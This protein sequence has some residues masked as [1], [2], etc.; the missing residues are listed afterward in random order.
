[1]NEKFRKYM[2]Y[3]VGEIALIVVGIFIAL[4]IDNWNS[5]RQEEAALD[6][7]LQSIMGNVRNDLVEIQR[8]QELRGRVLLQSQQA[9]YLSTMPH[10]PIEAVFF[11][12]RGNELIRNKAHFIPNTSG[13]EALKSSGVLSKLHGRD[14]EKLLFR[15]YD[16][17]DR[18]QLLERD[19][20]AAQ[21]NLASR[22]EMQLPE[23]FQNYTFFDPSGLT[24]G[25]FEE[26]QPV[27]RSFFKSYARS[28]DLNTLRASILPIVREYD[29]LL[30]LGKN[31]VA[32]IE[33]DADTFT[34]EA[35]NTLRKLDYIERGGGDPDVIINGRIVDGSY[36][37][38]VMSESGVVNPSS[39][40]R[41]DFDYRSARYSADALHLSYYGNE[42]WVV[43][44]FVPRNL[45]SLE[46]RPAADFSRYNQLVLE[47]K[48]E[49][50]GEVILV[51]LKDM[52]DPDDGSQTNVE[53]TL[54]EF[55][56]TYTFDLS[57]FDNADLEKLTVLSFLIVQ[58]EPLSFAI[59][60]ARFVEGLEKE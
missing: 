46:A 44:F 31:F 53:V 28:Q 1:M 5:D 9:G 17:V 12:S 41:T 56:Q 35:V 51:N 59:K 57:G 4:E 11:Y 16:V 15:Y 42:P 3:A 33:K 32:M 34:P 14:I 18:I 7:Y 26:L 54:T 22:E 23:S 45:S 6:S 47:M 40:V 19:L 60:T 29:K 50:G 36:Y 30:E 2:F 21:S 38:G 58:E 43:F 27:Y 24:P 8:L 48:G 55:W 39:D 49:S 10:I 52:D 25:Q 37:H 13:F 20:L